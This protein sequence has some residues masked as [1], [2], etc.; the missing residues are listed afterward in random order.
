MTERVIAEVWQKLLGLEKV[1]VNDNFFE[2]GGHSLLVVRAH[3]L[4]KER[5]DAEVS[6]IELFKHPTIS[7]L[8]FSISGASTKAL[9]YQDSIERGNLRRVRRSRRR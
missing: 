7:A 6:L 8:A 5:L 9:A 4:L 2:L 1:G 3:N